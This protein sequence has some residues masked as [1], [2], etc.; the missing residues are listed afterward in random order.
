MSL[1]QDVL[2]PHAT[3]S[4]NAVSAAALPPDHA[5]L[6][7]RWF[8][9][10]NPLFTASALCVLAGVFLA[11]RSVASSSQAVLVAGSVLELYQWLLIGTAA[12]LYRRLLERRPAVILGVI[13][14]VFLVD[15]TLELSALSARDDAFFFVVV[16]VG[17]FAAKLNALAWAFRLRLSPTARLL[18]VFVA[19]LVALVQAQRTSS[20]MDVEFAGLVVA[21]GAFVVAASTS[22]LTLTSTKP[23]SPAG[24]L[25][26]ARVVPAAGWIGVVGVTYQ[27]TNACLDETGLLVLCGAAVLFGRA[28]QQTVEKALWL[29]VFAGFVVAA[30]AGP[31]LF[32]VSFGL[33]AFAL[34]FAARQHAPRVLT[35]GVLVAAVV[36]VD[37]FV[38][39]D[40]GDLIV[41]GVATSAALTLNLIVRRGWSSLPP[42]LLAALKGASM[43]GFNPNDVDAFDAGAVL[44]VGGFLLLPLGVA[45]HRRLSR[46]VDAQDAH[47]AALRDLQ[48]QA[49]E[50]SPS[51]SAAGLSAS[52]A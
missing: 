23:L 40:L 6:W 9:Q 37:F 25:V 36:C 15:P 7:V 33:G 43:A 11:V 31:Q 28:A 4:S 24:E 44:V 18:P 39:D 10:Y 29:Q 34:L 1:A 22:T 42:V 30:F 48:Q 5:N 2:A 32:A 46:L 49:T 17:C 13:A 14:L 27:L 45:L 51:S 3:P 35:V 8:V 12:L 19:A 41:L 21:I 52:G 47:D 26:L 16:F 50:T 20:D 38:G